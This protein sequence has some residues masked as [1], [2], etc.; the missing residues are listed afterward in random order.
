MG[1]LV[2]DDLPSWRRVLSCAFRFSPSRHA[3]FLGS[4]RVG[5]GLGHRG[6]GL[7]VLARLLPD[8]DETPP[9]RSACSARRAVILTMAERRE[10]TTQI[11]TMVASE[12]AN[13]GCACCSDSLL[14]VVFF[15][16]LL[17]FAPGRRPRLDPGPSN[18]DV[19]S[20]VKPDGWGACQVCRLTTNRTSPSRICLLL[21]A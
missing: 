19:S 7:V 12:A 17:I 5:A 16:F 13:N 3:K 11:T 10:K 4:R 9:L 15:F 14:R 1:W 20:R 8:C 2:L 18:F 6:R 21:R